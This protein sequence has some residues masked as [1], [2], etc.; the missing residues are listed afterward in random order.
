[1][2]WMKR[3]RNKDRWPYRSEWRYYA[4]MGG[5]VLTIPL[6]LGVMAMLLPAAGATDNWQVEGANGLLLVRGR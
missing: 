5:V 2:Q 4:A 1:M 6:A 3:K